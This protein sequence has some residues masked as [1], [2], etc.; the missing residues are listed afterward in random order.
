MFSILITS[1]PS[2][3]SKCH[4]LILHPVLLLSTTALLPG[5]EPVKTRSIIKVT[6]NLLSP[7]GIT[8]WNVCAP[9]LTLP[10]SALP[11]RVSDEPGL[12]KTATLSVSLLKGIF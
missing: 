9:A 7:S 6:Q 4:L 3:L 11:G 8:Q 1:L 10:Q 2:F 5:H 12:E